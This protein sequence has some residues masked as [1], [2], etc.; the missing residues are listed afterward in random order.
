MKKAIQVGGDDT[1]INYYSKAIK[2]KDGKTIFND[3][4]E[5]KQSYFCQNVTI[6]YYFDFE[7]TKCIPVILQANEILRLAETIREINNTKPFFDIYD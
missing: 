7:D 5:V 3:K 1:V 6:Y 2:D 4:N